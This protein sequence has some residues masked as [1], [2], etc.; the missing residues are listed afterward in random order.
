MA[1]GAK[2]DVRLTIRSGDKILVE[3]DLGPMTRVDMISLDVQAGQD[4]EFVVD[5]GERLRFPCAAVLGDPH[6]VWER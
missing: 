5:F 2:G 6:V 1:A 4:L 3:R